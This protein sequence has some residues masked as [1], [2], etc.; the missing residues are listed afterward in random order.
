MDD[1]T[2]SEKSPQIKLT[3]VAASEPIQSPSSGTTSP[4]LNRNQQ[5]QL[6][7]QSTATSAA[8]VK[9]KCNSISLETGSATGMQ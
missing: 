6:L 7:P 8:N 1:T 9:T 3:L 4:T 2:S 5:Q